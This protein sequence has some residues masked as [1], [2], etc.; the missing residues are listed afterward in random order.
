MRSQT[1]VAAIVLV[2]LLLVIVGVLVVIRSPTPAAVAPSASVSP[3]PTPTAPSITTTASP[4]NGANPSANVA[5]SDRYGYLAL[6]GQGFDLTSESGTFIQQYG[7]GA[8]PCDFNVASSP[9]GKRVA[10][11]RTGQTP[12][13][14]LRVF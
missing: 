8:A 7:C 11:W 1:R 10:Y 3:T 12:Q 6:R 2:V 9:D 14:E 13:W 5:P 4:A